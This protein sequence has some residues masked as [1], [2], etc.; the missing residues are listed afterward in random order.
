MLQIPVGFSSVPCEMFGG[1]RNE[2]KKEL[3]S[4]QTAFR[5]HTRDGVCQVA[6]IFLISSL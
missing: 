3:F 1:K 5:G 4:V 2:L 6:E